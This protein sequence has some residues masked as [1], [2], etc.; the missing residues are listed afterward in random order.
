M[1]TYIAFHSDGTPSGMFVQ[2][3][4][5]ETHAES[6]VDITDMFAEAGL[7]QPEFVERALLVDGAVTLRPPKPSQFY[8]WEGNEWVPDLDHKRFFAQQ[9][10]NMRITEKRTQ[11]L[12]HVGMLLEEY[13]VAVTQAKAFLD[14]GQPNKVVQDWADISGQDAV[15]AAQEIVD[16]NV[17][18]ENL[19]I[20]TRDYRLRAKH[21]MEKADTLDKIDAVFD[22]YV[23][24]LG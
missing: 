23:L 5:L 14:T 12:T 15:T 7:S 24:L 19:L 3:M 1:R 13:Q 10:L 16:R 17:Q 4:P 2:R 20:Q 11:S 22:R 18:M 6:Q 21:D 9:E 8:K